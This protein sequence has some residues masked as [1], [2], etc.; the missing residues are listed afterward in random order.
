M[1]PGF[2]NY[3]FLAK[4][5]PLLGNVRSDPRFHDLMREVKT[6]WEML[7]WNLPDSLKVQSLADHYTSRSEL[8]GL[9][10]RSEP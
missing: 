6:R 1:D 4:Y 10:M 9:A 5:D 8:S 2:I 3:P 7:G